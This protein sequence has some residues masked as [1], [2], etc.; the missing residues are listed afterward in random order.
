MMLMGTIMLK[1][2]GHAALGA[3][4]IVA[5]IGPARAQDATADPNAPSRAAADV[6]APVPAAAPIT[7][8]GLAAVVSQ[9]RFR[10]VS[11]SDEQIAAQAGITVSH[12]SGF[13]IGTWGSNLGGF[14]TYGGA[15]LELDLFGGYKHSF[16]KAAVDA[17]LLWYVYP[18]T[19][20]HNY[21]EPYAN[22][23]GTLGPFALKAGG[24]YAP[25]QREI[26]NHDSLYLYGEA[27]AAIP[28]TPVTLKSHLGYTTGKGA[29]PAGPTGHYLDWQL[30]ADV[31][32]KAL[33]FNLSYVD[34]D[35]RRR[36]ADAFYTSGNRR[37][38]RITDGAVVASLTAAF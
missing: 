32:Y 5:G 15:N 23:S 24:N 13:Y 36:A 19:G 11:Q 7:I 1:L 4:A 9:Y 28:R 3:I 31:T 10:G 33:T 38:H 20:G 27:N 37:G 12:Q 2:L 22:V 8:S 6:P 34:T 21:A 16:G 30:G 17:G 14:G 26:G 18:G 35:I 29:A 25:K